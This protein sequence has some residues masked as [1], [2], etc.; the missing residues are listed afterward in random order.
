MSKR[1]EVRVEREVGGEDGVE[2]CESVGE[3]ETCEESNQN[4]IF[5][6]Q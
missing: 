6:F 3:E 1:V 4:I 2:R 5:C